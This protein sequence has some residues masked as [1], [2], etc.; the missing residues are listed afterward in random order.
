MPASEP[1]TPPGQSLAVFA[2]VLYLANLLLLPGIA[3]VV[4]LLLYVRNIGTAAP[5]P[6]AHLRQTVSTWL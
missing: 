3:F 5:L 6:A 1:D 2:E 4:L